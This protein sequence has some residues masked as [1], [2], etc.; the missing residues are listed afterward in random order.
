MRVLYLVDASIYVF[1]AWH[2]IPETLTDREGRPVNAVYGFGGFLVR[3]L[4]EARPRHAAVVFDE[5]LTSSFRNHLLPDYK[6]NRDLPPANLEW[7]FKLCRRLA[8]AMGFATFA[9]RRYEADDLI[10]TLAKRARAKGYAM[11]YV[12]RDKDL[13]QLLRDE[14]VYW[15]FAAE[16]RIGAAQVRDAVGVDADQVVDWLALTGD[17]VDNVPGVPGIGAKTAAALLR[18]YGDLDAVYA[19][20]EDL[21][22]SSLRGSARW[23][24]LLAE[25]RAQVT[26]ARK[27]LRIHCDAPLRAS[28][29]DLV[30]QGVRR[31][32]LTRLCNELGFG[33]GLRQRLQGA[34]DWQPS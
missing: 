9:S 31:R 12:S 27:V 4:N 7:Q 25:H 10:G 19:Q 18:R 5:S 24:R 26:L 14:D 13:L 11:V 1:R 20:L 23:A 17:A 28:V 8:R 34:G 2:S 22:A 29:G 3:L 6:A 21:A 16:R 32:A 30:W 15:D 33:A